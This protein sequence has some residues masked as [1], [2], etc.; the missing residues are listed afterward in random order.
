MQ[1]EADATILFSGVYV[2][3]RVEQLISGRPG[4]LLEVH[5]L[6]KVKDYLLTVLNY[7]KP[8]KTSF[9]EPI[10]IFLAFVNNVDDVLTKDDIATINSDVTTNV[11][12][13]LKEGIVQYKVC[14]GKYLT[15]HDFTYNPNLDQ[16][17]QEVIETCLKER[18]YFGYEEN[19]ND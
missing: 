2:L 12:S 17:I 19:F 4:A 18:Y 13:L 9:G 5:V 6:T 8:F 10:R 11:V 1:Q 14:V 7:T 15:T 16:L 3:N